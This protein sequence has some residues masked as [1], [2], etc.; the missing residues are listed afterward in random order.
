[1]PVNTEKMLRK[2]ATFIPV[3]EVVLA[4][5]KAT[6][7]GAAHELILGTA[8]AIAGSEGRA[9]RAAAQIDV[10]T[11]SQVLLVATDAS[12]FVFALDARGR[13]GSE[14][15]RI[16]RER[17]TEVRRGETSLFGRKMTEIVVVTDGGVEA[18]F[19]VAKVHRRHGEAVID[20]FA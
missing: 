3:G 1:M 19:G 20:S 14:P 11:A 15:S 7:R 2:V 5:T 17:I 4:A 6:P 12:L 18:G 13:P 16:G 8:G 10:G 9:E